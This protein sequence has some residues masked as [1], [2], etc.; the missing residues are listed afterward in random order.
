VRGRVSYNYELPFAKLT[1]KTNRLTDGWSLS[2]ITRFASGL[3]VTFASFGDNALVY[4]QSNGVNSV[5][6]DLPNYTPGNLQIN[7][8][9]RNGL[10]YFN[11][12][13]FTPNALGTQ[14]RRQAALLLRTG[15]RHRTSQNHQ[16]HGK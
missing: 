10:P 12:S 13:L 5:S 6:I 1:G 15:N 7:H 3:P 14:G 8:N 9:P 2:G 11:T 4:V 16:T